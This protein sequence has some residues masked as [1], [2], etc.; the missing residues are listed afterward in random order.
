[1]YAELQ[2]SDLDEINKWITISNFCSI[3]DIRE[4]LT[5]L[6]MNIIQIKVLDSIMVLQMPF[7]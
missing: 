3:E 7:G 6:G 5:F 4:N 2:S 1:M